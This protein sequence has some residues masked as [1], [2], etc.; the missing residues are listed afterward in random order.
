MQPELPLFKITT[1]WSW[2]YRHFR[3]DS[4]LSTN[5]PL[6]SWLCVGSGY[7]SG[8]G[9]ERRHSHPNSWPFAA[10]GSTHYLVRSA[11]FQGGPAAAQTPIRF[12]QNQTTLWTFGPTLANLSSVILNP[13][14]PVRLWLNPEYR[15]HPSSRPCRPCHNSRQIAQD[16]VAPVL[17]RSR[18]RD[19]YCCSP[20]SVVRVSPRFLGGHLRL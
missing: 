1:T 6:Y 5:T 19:L 2:W 20:G 7:R 17:A 9:R 13:A 10:A 16:Q 14:L 12:H 3:G 18:A 8:T 4:S 15:W 11:L